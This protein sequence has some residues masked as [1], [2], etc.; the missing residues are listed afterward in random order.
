LVFSKS[1]HPSNPTRPLTPLQIVFLVDNFTH[2]SMLFKGFHFYRTSVT[3]LLTTFPPRP[4]TL[5]SARKS[6]VETLSYW[7]SP[8]TSTS[9][10][11]IV[12]IHGIGIGLLPYV[13]FLATL[14]AQDNVDGA[15]GIIAIEILPISFRITHSVL[16]R[17]E[18]CR[19]IQTILLRHGFEKFVLVTHSQV[20]PNSPFG[21]LDLLNIESAVDTGQLLQTIF[22]KIP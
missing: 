1:S 22:S 18:M 17:E 15:V 7:H 14:K 13:D 10:L 11:P 16:G 8:H 2:I 21:T 12:F 19:Q 9:K 3:R 4:L 6:P 5:I 20:H